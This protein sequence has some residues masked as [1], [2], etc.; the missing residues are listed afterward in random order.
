MTTR[1]VRNRAVKWG[2]GERK[3][4]ESKGGYPTSSGVSGNMTRTWGGG[5]KSTS[6]SSSPSKGEQ[7]LLNKPCSSH[8]PQ[9][10]FWM[11]DVTLQFLKCHHSSPC[12]GD[13]WV[14][15]NTQTWSALTLFSLLCS[16]LRIWF[17]HFEVG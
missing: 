12:V 14:E 11:A 7:W 16:P 3:K 10:P 17:Q 2:C 4:K 9:F 13:E 8:T 5:E 15:N 1:T 6:G